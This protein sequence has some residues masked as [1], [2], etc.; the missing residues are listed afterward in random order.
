[1]RFAT[2]SYGIWRYLNKKP[3]TH[4]LSSFNQ[5]AEVIENN[6]EQIHILNVVSANELYNSLVEP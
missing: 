6:L 4:L 3:D 2:S 1:M 5:H